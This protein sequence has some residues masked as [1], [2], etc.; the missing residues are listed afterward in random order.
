MEINLFSQI[1][2]SGTWYVNGRQDLTR[3]IFQNEN[4]IVFYAGNLSSNGNFTNDQ[5]IFVSDWKKT[6]N[7]TAGNSALIWENQLWTRD[8]FSAFP[9]ISGEWSLSNN[10]NESYSITQDNIYFTINYKGENTSGYFIDKNKITIPK[11]NNI[12]ANLS[13]DGTSLTWDNQIWVKKGITNQEAISGKKLCRFELSA[14]YLASQTL[15]S[16]W[17]G[18]DTKTSIFDPNTV[19]VI[20]KQ[21]SQVNQIFKNISWLAF[22]HNRI[23]QFRSKLGS[24]TAEILF[25]EIDII[26][27]DIKIEVQNLPVNSG[28]QT[29]H[30]LAVYVAGIHLGAAKTLTAVALC[31]PPSLSVK[32]ETIIFNHLNTA[33][34]ALTPYIDC[35]SRFDFTSISKV[36]LAGMNMFAAH[37]TLVDIGTQILWAISLSDCCYQFLPTN[38]IAVA[39][40]EC[41]TSCKRFCVSLG[42]SDGKFN[43]KADCL[44]GEV[45]G[46]NQLACDCW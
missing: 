26:V 16:V 4:K 6:A 20:D 38:A 36:N 31:S 11:W 42:K 27:N 9:S 13:T 32:S 46:G 34:I 29:L 41:D 30:P 40:S 45:S 17:A 37:S 1:D 43:Y 14:F 15:G 19:M 10:P 7:L 24:T 33:K 23:D 3:T 2:I 39:K 22:D 12:S 35:I 25:A 8:K 5:T 44:K 28:D 18:F 21:L